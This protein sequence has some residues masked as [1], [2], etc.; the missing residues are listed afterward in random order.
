M[1]VKG[2]LRGAIVGWCFVLA[3]ALA[4]SAE[5]EAES[6]QPLNLKT[7][8]DLAVGN[9]AEVIEAERGVRAAELDL[10]GAEGAFRSRVSVSAAARLN[11]TGRLGTDASM[12]AEGSLGPSV[13][14]TAT[15]N[16]ARL[17]GGNSGESLS[18]SYQVWPPATD[19]RNW[20]GITGARSA[21][22]MARSALDEAKAEASVTALELYK[23]T[24]LNVERLRLAQELRDDARVKLA[25]VEE[26]VA[27]GRASASDRISQEIELLEREESLASRRDQLV[28]VTNRLAKLVGQEGASLEVL[29]LNEDAVDSVEESPLEG[30][31]EEAEAI[32]TAIA[33]SADVRAR[34]TAL[35]SAKAAVARAHRDSGLNLA[36]NGIVEPDAS[37]DVDWSVGLA[38]SYALGDGG[39]RRRA[40]ESAELSLERAEEAYDRAVQS[41]TESVR[42]SLR[43]MSSA[44]RALEIARAVEELRHLDLRVA[45]QQAARGFLTQ[46]ELT[47]RRRALQTA[48]LD[49]IAAELDIKLERLRFDLL[50]GRVP[51]VLE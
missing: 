8:V 50:I 12:R 31:P 42:S 19:A 14:W 29:P 16:T 6:S 1:R 34:Q 3:L 47:S 13:T 43:S 51:S 15:A 11:Q 35:G 46:S 9:S 37:G 21:L 28:S 24:Q 10:D 25:Q 40:V 2:G 33:A 32:A 44:L 22:S 45:E 48:T 27:A 39:N 26:A 41:A 7:V 30:V 18:V 38:G 36:L 17:S 5:V 4:G 20:T 49:R 23:L